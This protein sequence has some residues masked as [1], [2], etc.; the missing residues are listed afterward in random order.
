MSDLKL[1]DIELHHFLAFIKP[2]IKTIKVSFTEFLQILNSTNGSGKTEFLKETSPFP[3]NKDIFSK[4]GYKIIRIEKE[5]V[6]YKLTLRL[7][8]TLLKLNRLREF[9]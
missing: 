1:L 5:G 4:D 7:K 8:R 9:K 3:I 2:R 6:I